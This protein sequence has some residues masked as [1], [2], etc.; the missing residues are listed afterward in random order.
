MEANN[1]IIVQ[2]EIGQ[3]YVG[4]D[5]LR[6]TCARLARHGSAWCRPPCQGSLVGLCGAPSSTHP[7]GPRT[8]IGYLATTL[9]LQGQPHFFF[10]SPRVENSIV[11]ALL[12]PFKT[13]WFTLHLTFSWQISLTSQCGSSALCAMCCAYMDCAYMCCAYM[14]CAD[15]AYCSMGTSGYLNHLRP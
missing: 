4:D 8:W 14:D 11:H 10:I 13:C 2:K 5:P 12:I 1:F 6:G 9:I 3:T 15:Q 7:T